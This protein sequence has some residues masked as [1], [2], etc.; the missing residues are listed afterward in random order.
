MSNLVKR[1][2]QEEF[3]KLC[4]LARQVQEANEDYR[5]GLLADLGA[6]EDDGRDVFDRDLQADLEKTE[7][8]CDRRLDEVLKVIQD[9]MWVRYGEDE[10]GAKIH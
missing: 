4:L 6:E 7:A 1:G 2:L 8:H 5:A 10:L 3:N 9:E